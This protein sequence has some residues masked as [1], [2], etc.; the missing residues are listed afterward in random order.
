MQIDDECSRPFDVKLMTSV[1]G[2]FA[3][4]LAGLAHE[5]A[6]GAAAPQSNHLLV[7]GT[8]D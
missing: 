1:V 6:V 3:G 5:R 8:R 2:P 4:G 7:M